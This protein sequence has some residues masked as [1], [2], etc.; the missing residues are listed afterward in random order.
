MHR[1]S[2]PTSARA[3]SS[4]CC[5]T[6]AFSLTCTATVFFR[7]RAREPNL[8]TVTTAQHVTR[9]QLS[10]TSAPLVVHSTLRQ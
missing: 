7:P 9:M 8:Q 6:S 3:F 5:S 2:P 10:H 1:K 4:C